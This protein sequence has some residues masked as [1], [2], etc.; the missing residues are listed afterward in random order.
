[1]T[2]A[3]PQKRTRTRKTT[4]AVETKIGPHE[5]S[6]SSQ[7][8]QPLRLEHGEDQLQANESI[9]ELFS[10]AVV[11]ASSEKVPMMNSIES[12]LRAIPVGSP[13]QD[14]L[15]LIAKNSLRKTE[16]AEKVVSRQELM[17]ELTEDQ[18][19][20]MPLIYMLS[21]TPF[22][23]MQDYYRD[24]KTPAQWEAIKSHVCIPELSRWADKFLEY[25]LV[26]NR[27]GRGED[28]KILGALM[29]E[30][31]EIRTG[32]PGGMNRI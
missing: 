8:F 28:V 4:D 25:G 13:D 31:T 1:M 27:K 15:Y 26:V 29:Q 21:D 10:G 11:P 24:H 16:L 30:E 14:P 5:N 7:E 32:N 23:S 2:E 9:E 20:D 3:T 22:Y 19:A 17:T 6:G 18:R 12:S